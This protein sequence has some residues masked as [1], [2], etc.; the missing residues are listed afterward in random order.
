MA[1]IQGIGERYR[2]ESCGNEIEVTAAG[3]GEIR[4]CGQPMKR[5]AQ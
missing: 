5:I 1:Y 2:C 4:C 3:G